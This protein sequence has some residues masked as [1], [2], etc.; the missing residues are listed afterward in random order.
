MAILTGIRTLVLPVEPSLTS[1]TC[2]TVMPRNSTG[3]PVLSP[4]RL[5]EVR[6]VGERLREVRRREA[7][8]FC[9]ARRRSRARRRLRR[10]VWRIEGDAAD[11][12]RDERLGI[13]LDASAPTD[14]SMPL[15]FQRGCSR[16]RLSWGL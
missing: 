9:R 10:R 7:V 8:R 2:P 15:A 14:M 6:H 4:A 5:I 16:T 3:A 1:N 12:D 13:D 11:Q